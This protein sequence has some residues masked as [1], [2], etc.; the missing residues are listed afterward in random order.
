MTWPAQIM[1]L[2]QVHRR[3]EGNE[4]DV[5]LR[6]EG[7]R[8]REAERFRHVSSQ[9]NV[10]LQ[11]LAAAVGYSDNQWSVPPRTAAAAAVARQPIGA[12]AR[13][14]NNSK[15]PSAPVP[16]LP[17]SPLLLSP[18]R[19][20]SEHGWS[21]PNAVVA[22]SCPA[23][24]K[25][26]VASTEKCAT[27][28]PEV[29]NEREKK[30]QRDS[31][32]VGLDRS[33]LGGGHETRTNGRLCA[34][35]TDTIDPPPRLQTPQ[36]SERGTVRTQSEISS[37]MERL[38]VVDSGQGH[39]AELPGE[40]GSRERLLIARPLGPASMTPRVSSARLEPSDFGPVTHTAVTR[41]RVPA[42]AA[43]QTTTTTMASAAKVLLARKEEQ[44]QKRNC[45]LESPPPPAAVSQAPSLKETVAS[46]GQET[47]LTAEVVVQDD[48]SNVLRGRTSHENNQE[49][50]LIQTR[51]RL[52]SAAVQKGPNRRA[53]PPHLE[54]TRV[55][56]SPVR[57]E[58]STEPGRVSPGGGSS[59]Q[60]VS[61]AG[62][63]SP[64][65]ATSIAIATA[66]SADDLN[67]AAAQQYVHTPRQEGAVRVVDGAGR[68]TGVPKEGDGGVAVASGGASAGD[69]RG[70][71][72][73][74]TR[75]LLREA[76]RVK[77]LL[78]AMD[79]ADAAAS[80]ADNGLGDEDP[81]RYIS[82]LGLAE[83]KPLAARLGEAL[84][85]QPE[86][87]LRDP[88]VAVPEPR[89]T[90]GLRDQV[91][92]LLW[93]AAA[94]ALV[95]CSLW[96]ESALCLVTKAGFVGGDSFVSCGDGLPQQGQVLIN[97]IYP[98]ESI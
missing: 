52:A 89:T 36:E 2:L 16:P 31:G 29:V 66:A 42:S 27:P 67:P 35:R 84:D 12:G 90:R 75:R 3:T 1:C 72:S 91:C 62:V 93:E 85:R 74:A 81:E 95:L 4:S 77:R 82:S 64:F 54:Q 58:T 53:T 19:Q 10:F 68:S 73:E 45:S 5:V 87:L 98:T 25:A 18:A 15:G 60:P 23:A 86:A 17:A 28:S 6:F 71:S 44:G 11:D 51:G 56:E 9:T 63:C 97:S 34:A 37:G 70:S 83:V 50:G 69:G 94:R 57:H 49:E 32:P 39:G 41:A 21:A 92:R 55:Q 20:G 38:S 78:A 76:L 48:R 33:D 14:S 22:R 61:P 46:R 59:A 13:K 40:E 47:R 7:V 79:K 65:A 26:C 43:D 30:P 80:T 88:S 24:I 8:R 96:V